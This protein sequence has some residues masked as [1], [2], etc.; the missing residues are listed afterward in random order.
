MVLSRTFCWAAIVS[1]LLASGV[2]VSA[3]A[4][5]IENDSTAQCGMYLAVSSTS[6]SEDTTWGLYA[7][8]EIRENGDVGYPDVGI[9][10]FHLKANV[11]F[12]E[13]KGR[14]AQAEIDFLNKVVDFM[15]AFIWV[16][17]AAGGR[18]ELP[19]GRTVTA[20]PGGGVLGGFNPKL[21]NAIWNHTSAYFRP[22]WG[23]EEGSAHPGRG[24]YSPFFN[25]GLK[26]SA[27]IIAG[28]EVFL[29]Y[30]ENW[31]EED[32][33][34]ELNKDDHDK[35]DKTII[36]MI[37]FFS[38]HGEELDNDA[39]LKVYNFL[40]KDIMSAAIG[41]SKGKKVLTVLPPTPDGLQKVMDD[42]GSLAHSQPT[43]YR[44]I[45]WLEEHGRCM[46]N[47]RPGASTVPS[48]GRGAFATRKI[49]QD[50]L[51]APAP[52]IQIPDKDVL[53]MHDV[54]ATADGS[55]VR[56][57]DDVTGQQ[58][59]LNYCYGHSESKMLLFPTGSAVSL[60]NHSKEPNARMVWSTHQNHNKAWLKTNPRKLVDDQN[61]YI[62][63]MMEI[64]A[65]RDIEEG[66]EIFIDYGDEWQAAWDE[67]VAE[68]NTKI[69]N[70]DIA[71]EWPTRA[72]DLNSIY[73]HKVYKTEDELKDEPYPEKVELKAFLML[74]HAHISAGTEDDP[75][76]W[77]EEKLNQ[78]FDSDHLN[79]MVVLARE[80]IEDDSV[81]MPYLYTLRWTNNEGKH[82]F[83]KDV[84]HKAFVFVDAPGT[85]D[86]F[87]EGAFRHHIG[88]PDDI[89]PAGA[90][91]NQK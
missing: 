72:V 33:K 43:I 71:K 20:I 49:A 35:I 67:H 88:I 89:F 27:E 4:D 21:T 47:I 1:T 77:F 81:V 22:A 68:W 76:I 41:A 91:R 42:G 74:Q 54:T 3:A 56:E 19:E 69:E 45:E 79:N 30:G 84:P 11:A 31:A 87:T 80:L 61:S 14:S 75:K 51:V 9:N 5:D 55:Y 18:F 60:I 44:Q 34:E 2:T 40:I 26:A 8:K 50:G 12:T 15:E 53:N 16:P 86:Q 63:L 10:L 38:K 73:E 58:L 25:V 90:W 37:A 32:K 13:R 70:G 82:T 52:L 6:T 23:E 46:D 57:S 66:E 48:A 7:G 29:D 59:I 65:L 24:A 85:G 62:G 36:K 17:D 64:V 39:K 83:V 28:S 78:A